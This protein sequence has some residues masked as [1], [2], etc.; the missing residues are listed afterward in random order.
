VENKFRS[1]RAQAYKQF[2]C[3]FY[4]RLSIQ[5]V[6]QAKKV[7]VQSTNEPSS[8]F[9][10]VEFLHLSSSLVDLFDLSHFCGFCLRLYT[11]ASHACVN[12]S[13]LNLFS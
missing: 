5:A 12:S 4:S 6:P 8:R 2:V 1:V 11:L 9:L 13:N 7:A 10:I 3:L